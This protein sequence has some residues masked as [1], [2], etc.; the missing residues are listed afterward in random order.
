MGISKRH[1]DLQSKAAGARGKTEVKIYGGRRL[2][3][4]NPI[5]NTVTEVEKSGKIKEALRRLRTQDGLKKVLLVPQKEMDNAKLIAEK[6]KVI[7][8]IQNLS[9]TKTK[10]ARKD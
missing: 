2:D 9:K 10:Y 3:A 4:K 5:V 8:K 1:K 6:L 7:C